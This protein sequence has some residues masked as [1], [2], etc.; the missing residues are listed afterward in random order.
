MLTR[1]ISSVILSGVGDAFLY[2]NVRYDCLIYTILVFDKYTQFCFKITIWKYDDGHYDLLKQ[3]VGDF[4]WRSLKNDTI[5]T[6]A[7]DVTSKMLE[8][9]KP[10]V[11]NKFITIRLQSPPWF[12]N[13]IRIYNKLK[14]TRS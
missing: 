9:C 6:Y 7:E 12:Y 3:C 1:N 13:E 5:N 2:Q 10:T 11:P 8:L 4:D 14:K